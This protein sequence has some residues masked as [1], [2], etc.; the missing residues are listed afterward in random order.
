MKKLL[1]ILAS[2][3]MVA[4]GTV[5]T[6]KVIACGDK[7]IESTK[8]QK[9]IEALQ[10]V[11]WNFTAEREAGLLTEYRGAIKQFDEVL[12]KNE[13]TLATDA[14]KWDK[15]KHTVTIDKSKL[16]NNKKIPIVVTDLDETLIDNAWDTADR[17]IR[18]RDFS[19]GDWHKWVQGK[20]APIYAGGLDFVHHV[21]EKGGM[22]IFTSD[23]NQGEIGGNGVGDE[24]KDTYLDL[25][26]YGLEEELMDNYIWQDKGT[27]KFEDAKIGQTKESMDKMNIKEDRYIEFNKNGL[28]T[29]T[30][31]KMGFKDDFFAKKTIF[32]DGESTLDAT[33]ESIQFATEVVMFDG[34]NMEDFNP[35]L[36]KAKVDYIDKVTKQVKLRQAYM[37]NKNIRNS[38]G[39]VG[40][41]VWFTNENNA[42]IEHIS[43]KITDIDQN[44]KT[45]GFV[46]EIKKEAVNNNQVTYFFVAGNSFYGSWVMNIQAN[47]TYDTNGLMEYLH[48]LYDQYNIGDIYK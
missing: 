15:V 38:W 25:K 22:V 23:R 40:D 33:T 41:Y 28:F 9:Q 7:D 42:L 13:D 26:K 37:S 21:W 43:D 8:Y 11:L 6:T 31:N 30:F 2:F 12:E 34:D 17:V 27:Y 4:V 44:L 24:G 29:R 35:T 1:S 5:G 3:G 32:K 10:A 36:L 18:H 20:A 45:E 16:T 19:D 46:K 48:K 14:V 47:Y 39:G